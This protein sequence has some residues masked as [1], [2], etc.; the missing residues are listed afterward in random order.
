MALGIAAVQQA[1]GQHRGGP[2]ILVQHARAAGGLESLGC[3]WGG[4]QGPRTGEHYQAL[5]GGGQSAE[6][7]GV[8]PNH[9]A[10]LPAH[11]AQFA[12]ATAVAIEAVQMIA[13]LHSGIHLRGQIFI[14]PN[15]R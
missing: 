14:L 1:V 11:A 4:H 9:F 10:G 3:G 5:I 15:L 12:R 2:A 8:F 13:D 7:G 6:P